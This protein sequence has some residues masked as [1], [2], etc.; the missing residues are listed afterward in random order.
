MAAIGLANGLSGPASICCDFGVDAGSSTV[1]RQDSLREARVQTSLH[2]SL[3]H[4]ASSAG[5][6][7]RQTIE[8]LCFVDHS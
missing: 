3:Q 4:G 7:D 6:Q 5:R 1:K 2:G 8:K